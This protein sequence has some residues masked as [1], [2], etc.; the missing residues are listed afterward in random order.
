ME[1]QFT[2]TF[3]AKELQTV[4]V[5][6]DEL[7]HRV[8]RELIDKIQTEAMLQKNKDNKEPKEEK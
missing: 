5:G 6:L 2:F 8:S 3:T 4:L 7:P 1:Q